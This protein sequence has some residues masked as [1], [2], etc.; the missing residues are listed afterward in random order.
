MDITGIES[1][2]YGMVICMSRFLFIPGIISVNMP[3]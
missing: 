2:D 3:T 1:V